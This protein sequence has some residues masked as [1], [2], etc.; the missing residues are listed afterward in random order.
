MIVIVG[1][2]ISGAVLAERCANIL[3]KEVL[4][5]EKRDHIGGNCYDFFDSKGV[6]VP[7]Y[8]PHF[9][10]TSNKIVWD[11]VSNFT[12]WHKY[13]HRVLSSVDGLL[14]PI[15]VNIDTVNMLFRLN[16]SNEE[17]MK[18]WLYTV[19]ER[20]NSPK[21]SEE[22]AVAR[23]GWDLYHLLFENYTKKQWDM[24]PKDL[25]ASIMNR[26]PV[27]TNTDD[28]YFTDKFQAMPLKGYFSLFNNL[29]ENPKIRVQL[30][31]DYFDIKDSLKNVESLF[32][33]GR[34]DNYF[35]Y[36]DNDILQYRSLYF[37]YESYEIDIYQK[38]TQINYPNDYEYTRITEPKHATGQ[39]VDTTTIIK[40]YPTWDGEP[41]YPV[42]T[43]KN[44]N[45]YKRYQKEAKKLES[46]NVFF[47]GR[48]ANYK[49]FN[50]DQAFLNALDLFNTVKNRLFM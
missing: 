32:F 2:G 15:P 20:I 5:I 27:R 49:Y 34:V 41:Y 47:V 35:N 7:K 45:I 17:Q 28:R 6:L 42:L 43:E 29:L 25:D 14:V 37:E 11:Y 8:G 4:V 23:V 48:L 10:H 26:I 33:T 39:A 1:A 13:E 40:E 9:F 31:T 44:Q 21:N 3:N 12:Q 30:C 38:A 50:M 22:S 18:R 24:H 36:S 19:T 16:L 46:K